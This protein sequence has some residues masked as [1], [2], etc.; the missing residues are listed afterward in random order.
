MASRA[1]CSGGASAAA[2][3]DGEQGAVLPRGKA[4][5]AGQGGGAGPLRAVLSCVARIAA[6]RP[7]AQPLGGV[8]WSGRRR[9]G[10]A[11]RTAGSGTEGPLKETFFSLF[12]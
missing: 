4:G 8:R 3:A 11:G 10:A 1:P 5:G 7:R 2:G 9:A 12:F 6:G